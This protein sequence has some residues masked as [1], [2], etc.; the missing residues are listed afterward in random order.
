MFLVA[1]VLGE[2]QADLAD[3]LPRRV[4]SAQPLRDRAAVA[5]DFVGEGTADVPPACGDPLAVD[6]LSAG[7]RRHPSG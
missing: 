5:Y 1:L 6:V 4:S 2:V 3:D 7:D